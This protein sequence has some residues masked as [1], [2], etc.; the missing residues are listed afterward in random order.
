[1]KLLLSVYLTDYDKTP[2]AD[3][4]GARIGPEAL[5]Y[6]RLRQFLKREVWDDTNAERWDAWLGTIQFRRNAIH[7][8]RD[9]EIGSFKE[10]RTEVATF[11]EFLDGIEDRF[12]YPDIDIS[13]PY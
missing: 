2:E 11:W 6:E 13:G 8:Y 3:R 5:T 1:M 10:F 12:P 7:A 4:Q 9:R